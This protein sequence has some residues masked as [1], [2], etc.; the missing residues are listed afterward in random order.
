M[1]LLRLDTRFSFYLRFRFNRTRKKEIE[2]KKKIN[3]L[4]EKQS[5]NVILNVVCRLQIAI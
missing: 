1:L 2:R 5:Q 3:N 4:F